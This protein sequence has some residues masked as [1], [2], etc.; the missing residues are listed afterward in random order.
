MS[1]LHITLPLLFCQ[2]FSLKHLPIPF[3]PSLS[4]RSSFHLSY[5][6]AVIT[7]RFCL[8]HTPLSSHLI[9]PHPQIWVHTPS[10]TALTLL[11]NLHELTTASLRWL[12][13]MVTW[14]CD[15]TQGTVRLGDKTRL[16]AKD[17]QEPLGE[18]VTFTWRVQAVNEVVAGE[19]YVVAPAGNVTS[20]MS[21]DGLSVVRSAP[22]R[23]S[24]N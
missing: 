23:A 15:S 4:H 17:R 6:S 22:G 16:W 14:I 13:L 21:A 3:P 11:I 2:S 8:Y 10:T 1:D 5:R 20:Q 19:V 7:H 9:S 24:S 18:F 12:W